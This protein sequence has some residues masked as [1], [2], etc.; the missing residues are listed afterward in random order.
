[1]LHLPD[2]NSDALQWGGAGARVRVPGRGGVREVQADCPGPV[3]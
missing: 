1:M 3:P 2:Y